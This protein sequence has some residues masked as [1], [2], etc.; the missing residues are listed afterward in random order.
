MTLLFRSHKG[1]WHLANQVSALYEA[2]A[3]KYDISAASTR[4][5][6][7]LPEDFAFDRFAK[8]LSLPQ[9]IGDALP[10]G[11]PRNVDTQHVL[12][13]LE[14]RSDLLTRLQ[15]SAQTCV[16][17]VILD[18]KLWYKGQDN[19]GK[20]MQAYRSRIVDLT[21]IRDLL[22][23]QLEPPVMREFAIN[24]LDSPDDAS[25]QY[26][27]YLREPGSDTKIDVSP[28]NHLHKM[29]EFVVPQLNE[30][31]LRMQDQISLSAH[32]IVND[33]RRV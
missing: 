17:S 10:S 7:W 15:S 31:Q 12:S 25:D 4:T 1:I 29:L 18:A 23:G 19:T 26:T 5:Q 21:H 11:S 22:N 32:R 8:N 9:Y 16:T 3:K 14:K 30:S 24:F 2:Y 33:L 27:M 28:R 20:T 6:P 13:V